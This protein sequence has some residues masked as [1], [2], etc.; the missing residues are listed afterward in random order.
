MLVCRGLRA[1]DPAA[2]PLRLAH[3]PS[4]HGRALPVAPIAPSLP[5]TLVPMADSRRFSPYTQI[6]KPQQ[7]VADV[8]NHLAEKFEMQQGASAVAGS[9]ARRGEQEQAF[10]E[11]TFPAS[12]ITCSG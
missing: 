12:E 1:C 6:H 10:N 2:P 5:R 4:R 7:Q 8:M 9:T 11:M 3:A